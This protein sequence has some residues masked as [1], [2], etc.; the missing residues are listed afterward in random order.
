MRLDEFDLSNTVVVQQIARELGPADG[1]AFTTYIAVHGPA[2]PGHCGHTH[3]RRDGSEPKTVGDAIRFIH[4][5]LAGD[6]HSHGGR[7]S[8]DL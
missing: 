6:P 1:I 8:G 4:A 3:G 7:D 2:S 5:V